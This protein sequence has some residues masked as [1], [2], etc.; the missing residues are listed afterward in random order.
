ME[1]VVGVDVPD[2]LGNSEALV[3][4]E[5]ILELDDWLD[6]IGLK[7]Q[8]LPL[9]YSMIYCIIW[10]LI[11]RGTGAPSRLTGLLL[12]VKPLS[13]FQKDVYE[14]SGENLCTSLYIEWTVDWNELTR[15]RLWMLLYTRYMVSGLRSN[16]AECRRC[17]FRKERSEMCMM[18]KRFL[19][20]AT[21]SCVSIKTWTANEGGADLLRCI[22]CGGL[23]SCKICTLIA[24]SKLEEDTHILGIYTV[25]AAWGGRGRCGRRG[26]RWWRYGHGWA[27]LIMFVTVRSGFWADRIQEASHNAHGRHEAFGSNAGT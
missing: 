19:W 8:I 3:V 21:I 26:R 2:E 20:L 23:P 24:I 27:L 4:E 12:S 16:M 14:V 13:T 10:L 15:N 11:N 22:V 17:N 7:I 25:C 5:L 9:G 1:V 6:A 18:S